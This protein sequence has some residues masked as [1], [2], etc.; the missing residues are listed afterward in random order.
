LAFWLSPLTFGSTDGLWIAIWCLL[1][2]FSLV[3]TPSDDIRQIEGQV[4]WP[5][6]VL[7]A[8][9]GF[10][11]FLQT[12]PNPWVGRTDEA[13]SSVQS[14]AVSHPR[15]SISPVDGGPLGAIGA[16][17]VFALALLRAY[18]FCTER[19]NARILLLSLGVVGAIYAICSMI[20]FALHLGF[21][22]GRENVVY[23]GS[24]TGPFVNRNTAATYWGSCS[25][26][27]LLILLRLI[28]RRLTDKRY[29][30]GLPT[31]WA[32]SALWI[33][34]LAFVICMSAT[35]LT[36]SRAGAA[37]TLMIGSVIVAYEFKRYL[38]RRRVRLVVLATAFVAFLLPLLLVGG[39]VVQRIDEAGLIDHFRLEAYRLTL[40]MIV[41][42]PWFGIGLG[43]FETVFP[44][45][46]N[47][48]LGSFGIWDRAHNSLLETTAEM[49]IPFALLLVAVWLTLG[50]QLLGGVVV[51]RRDRLYPIA[52]LAVGALGTLHSMVDFS[53]QISG[54]AIF[55]AAVVGCGLAQSTSRRKPNARSVLGSA[56]AA[57]RVGTTEP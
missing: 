19:E 13:W 37:L 24:L 17:L 42:H 7:L 40:K 6:A 1:L 47:G 15:A 18:I 49:G 48:L 57:K 32:G 8:A 2:A 51:R 23:A 25:L 21:G 14:L 10:L 38:A 33:T 34:W 43:N 12:W 27:W 56:A 35:L 39:K 5:L 28:R 46:R 29:L 26:I 11:V 52:G 4:L 55:F 30:S 20:M 54:Y 45:Y 9:A 3:L 36:R 44:A 53:L 31:G 50:R 22:S 41:D 16:S